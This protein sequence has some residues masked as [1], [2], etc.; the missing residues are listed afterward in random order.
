MNPFCPRAVA[1][2]MVSRRSCA[3]SLAGALHL[4][5]SPIPAAVAQPEP[6]ESAPP[7]PAATSSPTPPSPSPP[8]PAAPPTAPVPAPPPVQGPS[9]S[10]APT[11][12]GA[13]AA[14]EASP[15]DRA[16]PKPP[17]QSRSAANQ[18][19]LRYTLESIEVRGNA[20]TR[21]RVVL[22]YVPFH[23]GDIIDVDEPAIALTR[24]R[25]LGTGFF[26]DVQFNLRKGSS[27]GRVV[28]VIE[29]VERNTLVVSDVLM[30]IA[31][32]ASIHSDSRDLT[33]YAGFDIAETNLGGTGITLGAALAL[34]R[35]QLAL[36]LRF[37]DPAFLGGDFMTH[38][39]LIYS[40]AVDF[41]GNTDVVWDDPSQ[42]SGVPRLA[43]ITYNR[44]GGSLGAGTDLSV[45]TQLWFNYRLET[46][47]THL[48]RFASHRRGLDREPVPFDILPD[49]SVLSTVRASL[50]QDTRDKPF[51]PTTG[52]L[53]TLTGEVSLSP[54]G[55]DYAYQRLDLSISRWWKLPSDHVIR[56]DAFAGAIT[57]TAPFF[58][59]Y[60]VG[61]FSDFL[62]A[63]FL[64][65]SFDTR[66]SPNFL[67]T[68]II[69]I[70][71]ARYAGKLSGEYRIPL[72]RGTRSVYGID[73]FSNLGVF[74][75][76][77][78]RDIERPPSGYSGASRLPVDLTANLGFRMDTSA[79]GFS[80]AFANVLGFLPLERDSRPEPVQ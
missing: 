1:L 8:D 31:E 76:A 21:S 45:S 44:F 59:Q 79:G 10:S 72:Y 28:L 3:W 61:D 63:R 19:P 48:P 53:T 14:V 34:D 39:E 47:E 9:S 74:G 52:W 64:G 66:P 29:V 71:Y 25:L 55:S 56:L 68:D 35:S 38:G 40:D 73:F 80:F 15:A 43:P 70:R 78:P 75:I 77:N 42:V 57:G 67:G 23:P 17:G 36:R 22:R 26:R 41:A 49:H 62:P 6:P 51:L 32:G 27:R 54:T 4:L 5:L 58:E 30:G 13:S 12:P 69:E 20:K 65:L 37:L 33:P 24:Y 18:S 50:Q 60:Y 11:S 16:L 7:E 2:S 46:I